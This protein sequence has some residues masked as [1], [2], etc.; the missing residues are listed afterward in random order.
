MKNYF[1]YIVVMALGIVSCEPEF[2]NPV[3]E[4]DAYTN[5][6]ADF[7]RYVALG[8][9]L[10]AGYADNALYITG[11]ENA[12][13]NILAQQFEKTQ[14]IEEFTIPFMSD[15]AGGL[16]LAGNQITQNRL[17][18]AVDANGDPSPRVYTGM[19]P[20]TEVGNVLQG[21]FS[22][23]GV[24]GAKSYHLGFS[25][26]GNVQNLATQSAN[27]YFVRFA[28]SPEA[29]V[30]EDALA[31][32]PTFFSLWIGN[33]DVLGYATSGGTGETQTGMNPAEY[34]P[35]DITNPI[36]FNTIYQQMVQAL[37]A[38]SSGG[39]LI[40]IP[41]VTSVPFFNTVPFNPL[42]PEDPDQADYAAQI[43]LLNS[44]F[45]PLNQAFTFLSAEDRIVEFS[46]SDRS[47]VLV[48][49][50]SIPDLS[51]E[52]T[53][54]LIGGGLD[55]ATATLYGMQFGQMRPANSEDRIL[56]T[57]SSQIGGVNAERMQELMEAGLDQATAG[58]LSVNG[59]TY[60]LQDE[61]AL[62][63]EE[64]AIIENTVDAYNVIISQVAQANGLAFIDA[65]AMLNQ[66]ANGG[67]PYDGGTITSTFATGGAFSLDGIH[68][69]PRGNAVIANEII[70]TINET[71]NADIP[72]VNPGSYATVTA[73]NEVQ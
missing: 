9:S 37:S 60:P 41:D 49:D 65:N 56:L 53:Q 68:L 67:I 22:N 38:S 26:Y 54:V 40:N 29:T 32:N 16:L 33:N 46:K 25:G 31:Q 2:D 43:D 50:E 13:P 11:Q 45:A 51:A 42:D 61:L 21:P 18:L 34:G 52:L 14:D 24:P 47:A 72:K 73:S 28:S 63:P 69:T 1:K 15:N 23:L 10:T 3:D 66:L 5:G 71:Y 58:R 30:L 17:V 7:S 55:Q 59:I 57:A 19:Q 20:T 8:N 70:S 12:Y 62:I 6:E 64:L 35:D 4:K 39:V 48:H 36:V 44:T 27:P